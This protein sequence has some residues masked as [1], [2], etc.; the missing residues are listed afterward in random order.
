[1]DNQ[2]IIIKRCV[3]IDALNRWAAS[4]GH[5]VTGDWPTFE[6]WKDGE[7]KAYFEMPTHPVIYPGISPECSKRDTYEIC[8]KVL[9][10]VLESFGVCQ[11][12]TPDD[13][14]FTESLMKKMGFNR[15]R[16]R[17][18]TATK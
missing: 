14:L 3:D 15:Q 18:Y 9:S 11:A 10:E 5:S 13:T 7:L 2:G 6:V 8:K 16:R 17:L 1:M 4:F 12:V